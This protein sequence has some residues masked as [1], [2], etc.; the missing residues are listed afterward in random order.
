MKE[1]EKYRLPGGRIY[2]DNAATRL[3][4]EEA[5]NELIALKKRF[6][7]NASSNNASGK[8]IQT[9]LDSAKVHF[10]ERCSCEPSEL[11]FFYRVDF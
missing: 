2:L 1:L 7:G 11:I 8:A 3:M 4:T 6:P 10:A 9:E 5:L